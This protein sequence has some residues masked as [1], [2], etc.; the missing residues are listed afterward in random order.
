MCPELGELVRRHRL[1]RQLLRHHRAAAELSGPRGDVGRRSSCACRPSC[2]GALN[3]VVEPVHPLDPTIRG[4]THIQWTGRP[5]GPRAHARNAVFY[6]EKAIDR[7]PCGT[8]TSARM[9][10]LPPAA[11]CE[12]GDEFVHESI[13]GSEF[14]GRVEADDQLGGQPAIVPSIAGWARITG[15]QH[16]L[17]RR[18]R[19]LLARLP[20]RLTEPQGRTARTEF[21]RKAS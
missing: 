21:A 8:G 6:G 10:Q 17:R 15:L 9:A 19:P 4:V 13:I 11:G 5:R 14:E 20:G 16:D 7:S 18:A 3:E 2:A 12:D 1:R